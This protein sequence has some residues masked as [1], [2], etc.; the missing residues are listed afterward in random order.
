MWKKQSARVRI[1]TAIL[2]LSAVVGG[3]VGATT[4]GAGHP[5]PGNET[6]ATLTCVASRYLVCIGSK[7]VGRRFVVARD[8]KVDVSLAS[9]SLAWGVVQ[10]IGPK[11]LRQ[12]G[13]SR[14]EV[15]Y[16]VVNF[17]TVKSGA[18]TLQDTARP[19]CV[20]GQA[21]PQFIVLWR[22]QIDVR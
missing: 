21:C 8:Q 20:V 10:Q 3:A 22:V 11:V 6:H 14:S 16:V 15:G 17:A 9:A 2:G 12:V 18:T 5:P 4:L 19:I 1:L 13:L 7:D